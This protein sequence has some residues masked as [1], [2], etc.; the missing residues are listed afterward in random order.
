MKEIEMSGNTSVTTMN[1]TN[2]NIETVNAKDC[3][4]LET[5][6]CSECRISSI[7][8]EG[9]VKLRDLKFEG[10]AVRRFDAESLTALENLSCANQEA[11]VDSI[12]TV[13]NLDD[14]IE[15]SGVSVSAAAEANDSK[16]LNVKG[17]D[18]DGSEIASQY[19]A[20]T[21][22]V[23]FSKAPSRITDDYDTGFNGTLMDVSVTGTPVVDGDQ[24]VSS[25]SSGCSSGTSGFL[26]VLMSLAF[27]LS[28]KK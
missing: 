3:E 9:C 7:N 4:N 20:I 8:L 2:S 16:I 18:S 10:N 27:A 25:S 22:E 15:A 24:G 14:F 11:S 19:N 12:G 5:L 23:T 17:Y 13:F 6:T 28:R 1:L 26:A 21:G